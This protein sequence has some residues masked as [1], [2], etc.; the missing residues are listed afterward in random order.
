MASAP[1]VAIVHDWLYGGGA[2]KVVLELHRMFSDAPIYTSYCSDEWRKRL[3][4]KVVTGYLQWWPFA[5]ARKFLPLLRQWW[6][7]RLD[8]DEYDLI[9]STTGNGEAKFAH[10]RKDAKH[11]CYCFTPN[12]FYWEKYDEYIRHPG[13]GQLNGLARL[14]LRLLVRPL[15]RRDYNA[16]Q[17]IDQ[18]VAISSHIQANIK[19]FYHRDSILVSPPAD[20]KQFSSAVLKPDAPSSFITWGRHV[21]YKRFDLAIAACNELQLPLTVVG[22]G[23]ET[24]RLQAIAGSTVTFTGYLDDAAL[25]E[26]ASSAS[27]FLFPSEEDFG[28]APVEAMAIGLPVLAYRAGGA[29]DYVI[30]GKTGEFFDAQSVSAI[31]KTLS[32]FKPTRYSAKALRQHSE[33]F[34][35]AAFQKNIA[36]QIDTLL[37]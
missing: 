24:R 17:R 11:L 28:I 10:G 15:R 30:P 31:V 25:I 37:S 34:S 20:T 3:D 23:S 32:A 12:H 22:T 16:A 29:L 7:A 35:Q 13:M 1:K 8:L 2:E 14:G 4:N 26:Q 18:F 27:A 9:I 21:P 6:F 36:R 5:K 33:L 19:Q